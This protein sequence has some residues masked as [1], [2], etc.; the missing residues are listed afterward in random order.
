VNL[1]G[2]VQRLHRESGGAGSSPATVVGQ[3]GEMGRLVDWANEAWMTIQRLPQWA[4]QWEQA[5][6]TILAGTNV[7][8]Q[9]VPVQRLS[10]PLSD[11]QEKAFVIKD[12]LLRRQLKPE[13]QA[14][15]IAELY[16]DYL[17]TVSSSDGGSL[18]G[19]K[20]KIEAETGLSSKTLQRHKATHTLAKTVAKS[21]GKDKPNVEHYRKAITTL[22]KQR[23]AKQPEKPASDRTGKA[24]SSAAGQGQGKGR[25]D[26]DAALRAF[27]S[28]LNDALRKV[29][30]QPA[31]VL[32]VAVRHA[33]SWLKD[34]ERK[35]KAAERVK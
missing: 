28:A 23:R 14:K 10:N 25:G 33:K 30:M 2:I 5:S 24:Q 15:M 18:G 17:D 29:E 13:Q 26:G 21:E 27:N 11:E 20:K 3:A 12:N 7:T 22:N 9:S 6:I 32:K 31:A 35:H 19:L 16:P 34:V 4:W 8:A 1:L